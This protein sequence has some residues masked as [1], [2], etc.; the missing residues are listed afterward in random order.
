MNEITDA[1]IKKK[2]KEFDERIKA[3]LES[4]RG[5]SQPMGGAGLSPAVMK[6]RELAQKS[7]TPKG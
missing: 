4:V 2:H 7:L 3:V 1:A 5:T 6:L